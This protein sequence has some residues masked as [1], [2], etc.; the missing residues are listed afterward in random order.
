MI[1]KPPH[2]SIEDVMVSNN[3]ESREIKETASLLWFEAA[4]H[5]ASRDLRVQWKEE[6]STVQ[7]HV[8]YKQCFVVSRMILRSQGSWCWGREGALLVN[9]SIS[10][11]ERITKGKRDS[12]GEAGVGGGVG[13]RWD[14]R[15]GTWDDRGG[16][17]D[18]RGGTEP[19]HTGARDT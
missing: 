17:W 14:D 16:T 3:M 9:S 10:A 6:V 12:L 15:G 7:S 5:R 1:E 13:G 2:L 18:D 19:V 11:T 4:K 8:T